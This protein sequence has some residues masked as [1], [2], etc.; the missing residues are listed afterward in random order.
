MPG[1]TTV[2]G[3]SAPS[4]RRIR[5]RSSRF[6]LSAS[7]LAE[8]GQQL[9]A[10]DPA[11]AAENLDAA[12][13]MYR[14]L[15]SV[16]VLMPLRSRALLA[17]NEQGD[18]QAKAYFDQAVDECARRDLDHLLCDVVRV[19]RAAVIARLGEGELAMQQI[20]AAMA[21]MKEKGADNDNEFAQALESKAVAQKS[22]GQQDAA[23]ATQTEALNRYIALFGEE[24]SEV[25][26]V[27]KNLEQLR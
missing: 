12:I 17:R 3:T 18:A 8:I 16:M 24:H 20:D 7:V 1:I 9:M 13:A 19:N 11:K 27:R 15:D 6:R 26:R 23:I 10:T 25:V 14:T 22:L 5:L 21:A 4:A 2:G